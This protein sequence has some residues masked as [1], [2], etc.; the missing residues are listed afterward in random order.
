MATA[1]DS[2][3]YRRC[4]REPA[5]FTSDGDAHVSRDEA[6]DDNGVCALVP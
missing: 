4:R 1:A 3:P 6:R 5:F 2:R